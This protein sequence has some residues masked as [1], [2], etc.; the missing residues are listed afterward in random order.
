MVLSSGSAS[1]LS[2]LILDD[3][4]VWRIQDDVPQFLPASEKQKDGTTVLP[5]DFERRPDLP[6]MIL[7]DWKIADDLK[8]KLEQV[9][10]NDRKLRE[11]AEKKRKGQKK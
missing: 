11:T 10:R 3:E 5:S 7:K 4:I 1:W 6:Y 8:N 9:Q 2:H